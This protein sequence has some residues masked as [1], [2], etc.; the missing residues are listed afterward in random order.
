MR[1]EIALTYWG[2]QD[3]FWY[4]NT[5]PQKNG[6]LI[7]KGWW[8][9]IAHKDRTCY[10]GGWIRAIAGIVDGSFDDQMDATIT[11]LWGR[12]LPFG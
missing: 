1:D 5:T 9:K 11:S 2:L 12:L 8:S 10:E 4:K 3:E 7:E 6:W